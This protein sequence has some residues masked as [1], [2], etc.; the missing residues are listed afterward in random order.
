MVALTVFLV[1]AS[2]PGPVAAETRSGG[3]VIVREAETVDGLTAFGGSV[4]IR[5]TVQGDLEAFAGN[6]FIEG[7]VTGDVDAVAGNV[8]ISGDVGGD[9]SATG[10][11]VFIEPTA[12]IDGAFEA[13]AGMVA[14]GGT[15]D[16]D[17]SIAAGTLRL[18]RE[19]SLGGNLEYAVGED[20]QFIDE[21][22]SVAGSITRRPDLRPG[23]VTVPAATEWLFDI[24]GILVNLLL[25]VL[26]LLVFP[27]FSSRVA[28]RVADE[29]LR[30]GG[31]GLVTLVAVP[32]ALVLLAI[33]IIGIPFTII[34]S[35][36]FVLVAWVAAVYGR[37]A[38]G[39]WLVSLADVDSRW[40]GLLVGLV[41]VAIVKL[42]PVIDWLVELVVL[43]LGLGALATLGYG[44]YRGRRGSEA[45]VP[46]AEPGPETE[47]EEPGSP[48]S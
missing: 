7:E 28:R 37:F 9:V 18:S 44:A 43:L 17:V 16:D 3:T 6:V 38:V 8:R 11:N 47:P 5:G 15:V 22:A 36:L 46:A 40:A 14:I 24:Y 25:G 29:P 39:M 30:T 42:I 34:D 12:S 26:F 10:G 4:I 27:D 33:T 32:V 45:I 35:L 48:A 13:A 1:L 31:I 41:A 23:L 2:V 21:G 19:A 20:G